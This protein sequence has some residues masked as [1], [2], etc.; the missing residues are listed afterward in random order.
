MKQSGS[1]SKS[2]K[3]A[4]FCLGLAYLWGSVRGEDKLEPGVDRIHVPAQGG[5]ERAREVI[6]PAMAVSDELWEPSDR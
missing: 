5:D 4:V 3:W 6:F 1:H 2:R